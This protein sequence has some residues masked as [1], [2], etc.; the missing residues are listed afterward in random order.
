MTDNTV[1]K[2]LNQHAE[3]AIEYDLP[4]QTVSIKG[5][6]IGNISSSLG[7]SMGVNKPKEP[8]TKKAPAKK[9]AKS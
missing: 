2:E 4:E 3:Y 7:L 8:E 1:A 5:L 9:A 6:D